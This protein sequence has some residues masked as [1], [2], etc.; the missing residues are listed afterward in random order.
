MKRRFQLMLALGLG[1]LSALSL[2]GLGASEAA[3]ET[4]SSLRVCA[5]GCTYTNV[6]T[7]VDAA[8]AGDVI[9][10]A[11]GMYTSTSLSQVVNIT[12]SLTLQGGYSADFLTQD[13]EAYPTTL[14]AQ[15]RGRVMVVGGAA[16]ITVTL[17]GL[18]LTNGYWT[19]G[20]TITGL[21]PS[22][23]AGGGV[24]V[25]NVNL[26]VLNSTISGNRTNNGAGSGLLQWQGSLTLRSST[27]QSNTASGALGSAGPAGGGLALIQV[28][29]TISGAEVLS[30]TAAVGGTSYYAVS[31]VK[32]GGLYAY[33]STVVVQNTLFRGNRATTSAAGGSSGEGGGLRVEGGSLAITNTLFEGN[34]ASQGGWGG[35]GGGLYFTGQTTATVIA[36]QF[37]YNVGT[38]LRGYL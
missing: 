21:P 3:P 16:L 2:L 35:A 20:E 33:N 32:G 8:N 24:R 1:M 30:N 12:K 10:I 31:A 13:P 23:A 4:Q 29:T 17:D 11:G 28:T 26:T 34:T 6:Q 38:S 27:V 37:V 5:V 19:G 36:N 15:A 18:V 14:D 7:A 22:I 9:Q 25:Q